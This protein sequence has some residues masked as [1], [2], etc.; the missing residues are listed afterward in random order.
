MVAC[1]TCNVKKGNKLVDEAEHKLLRPPTEPRWRPSFAVPLFRRR[2]SWEHF[3][4]EAYWNVE[5]EE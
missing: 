4:S 3:V 5:L 1:L 2:E